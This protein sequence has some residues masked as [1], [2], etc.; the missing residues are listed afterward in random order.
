M[1]SLAKLSVGDLQRE[2]SR[3]QRGGKTLLRRRAKLAAKLAALD[4]QIAELG[5]RAG[6]NGHSGRSRPRNESNLVDALAK[7]LD[8]KTMSVGEAMEAV[9]KSGYKTTAA[10]F[11]VIVN[12]CLINSG[13]F[14]RVERG[15]YTAK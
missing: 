6:S 14:K 9:Q 8:G 13:K 11:R 10:N 12:Q 2:I 4:A 1:A 5:L 7:V 15:Q 3:R